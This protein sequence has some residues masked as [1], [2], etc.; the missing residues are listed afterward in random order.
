MAVPDAIQKQA[1][2]AEVLQKGLAS[3]TPVELVSDAPKVV[4]VKPQTEF[5]SSDPGAAPGQIAKPVELPAAPQPQPQAGDT[6]EHKYSVLQGKYN[7]ELTEL[8]AQVESQAGTIANLNSLI[9]SL[10]S[11]S[12]EAGAAPSQEGARPQAGQV[13]IDPDA[14]TGYGAEM[15][16]LVNLVKSQSAE[17]AKL[18]GETNFIAERQV[19]TEGE[20]YYDALDLAAS[21]WRTLNKDVDFLAWLKE[22]DGLSGITRQENMTAAHNALNSAGVAKY[23]LAY[24][25]KGDPTPKPQAPNPV[26]QGNALL[27]QVV[28]FDTGVRTEITQPEGGQPVV[29]TRAQFNKAVQDKVQNKITDAEFKVISD[30]FQRSIATG[31]V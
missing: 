29:V 18:K 28:P 26:T 12:P 21:D 2:R 19:K 6:W 25:A 15:I 23:F 9:V 13:D 14:F 4:N 24:K 22:P 27:N 8:H 30:N 31:Q 16:D 3:A 5:V 20:S 17:L 7:R 1:D 10:N 11:R